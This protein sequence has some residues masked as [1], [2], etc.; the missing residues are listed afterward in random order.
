MSGRANPLNDF[1][2]PT[3]SPGGSVAPAAPPA[4]GPAAA[5]LPRAAS[6]TPRK[7]L[8]M[9]AYGSI[10]HLIGSRM[11][12]GDHHAHAGQVAICTESVRDRHDRVIVTEKLDGSCVAVARHA[13]ALL[14]LNRAGY[15]AAS[16]PY[17]QHHV[18]AAWVEKN[19]ARFSGLSDGMRI[20]GEWILV[21]H[22]T[23]YSRSAD[24][25]VPFDVVDGKA[26]L[27]H[28]AA[29]EVF[30]AADLRG[31]HVI[32][33]GG[34]LSIDAALAALGDFGHH[35]AIEAVEGAVWRVERKGQLDFMAK[36]VRPEKIDG[37]YLPG[38][39]V[40]ITES[41]VFNF[42]PEQIA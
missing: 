3:A 30:A 4:A 34:P 6:S 10:P 16:S 37:L 40:S 11:G 31:A 23:R 36:Y 22:G 26:R 24:V 38:T 42:D 28:D 15:L 8:G 27:P 14:A 19:A 39:S 17:R 2:I 29:R 20:C 9:K 32:H 21:A 18:F 5:V 33:D 1:T 13:G 7:P 35:G 12:P 25:F 41:D